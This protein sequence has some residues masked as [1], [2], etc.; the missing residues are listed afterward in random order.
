MTVSPDWVAESYSFA[1]MK[2]E[3][4]WGDPVSPPDLTD[5]LKEFI[6]LIWANSANN[7]A[8]TYNIDY[9]V[10]EVEFY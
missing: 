2:R 4:G 8:G 9:S 1:D 10:D 3:S 5:H 7:T 6:S